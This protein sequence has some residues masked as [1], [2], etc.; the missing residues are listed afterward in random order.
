M[1]STVVLKLALIWY[2]LLSVL[3]FGLYGLDKAQAVAEGRRIPEKTLHQ[4]ALL[5]GFPGG[6]L[7]RT[8][9]RHKT[10]KPVFIL[11][12]LGSVAIHLILWVVLLIFFHLVT[13]K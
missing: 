11:V 5:G 8:I 6:L 10:R 12:L 13:Q 7:G 1:S 3:L 4:L 9:F 2:G